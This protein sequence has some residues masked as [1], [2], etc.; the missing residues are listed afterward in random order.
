MRTTKY[1]IAFSFLLGFGLQ[2]Q[3]QNQTGESQMDKMWGDTTSG[4]DEALTHR[5]K[6][7][8]QSNFGMFVHFGIYSQ[9]AGVW[10]DTT[11]YGIGEWLMNPRV[12]NIAPKEYMVKAKDFNPELFDAHAIA[13]L[14]K[15][16]GM[17]YII[18]GAKH[19]D[20]FALFDS[21][22][23]TFDVMDASP[24]KRDVF[25]EL[26]TA[27]REAGLG[28]GFY[29][30]HYQDW[31]RPG[32][33]GGPKTNAD[34]SPA[35][36]EDYFYKKCLPQVR[37]LCSNYGPMDFV[38]FDTPGNM[39][40][41][42]VVELAAE[43]RKL[44]PNAMLCSRIGYGMGD[45]VSK[46][47]MEVPL[48]NKAGLWETCDT[49]NDSWGY[50]WYDKN[51]KTPREILERLVAT[52][53]RGGTY[54]FNI[55]PMGT[56][57]VPATAVEFLKDAGAWLARYPEVVYEAG[58]SPWGHAMP[59]GDMTTA[60]NNL[61]LTVF[62]W[63]RDGKLYLP[64]LDGRIVSAKGLSPDK[65]T[66]ISW[67]KQNGWAVLDVPF[68]PFDLP[69]S[70][71]QLKLEKPL[72]HIADTN[73]IGIHPNME[74][75]LPVDFATVTG[76]DQSE[77]KWMEKFGEWKHIVRVNNWEKEGKAEWKITVFEPGYYRVNL[78]YAGTGRLV[79]RVETDG[80]TYIQNQQGATEKC[81]AYPIGL[82][83]FDQAGIHK[84]AVS[85]IDGDPKSSSLKSLQLI[86]VN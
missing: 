73:C 78:V 50:V 47:D 14:A 48:K 68:R 35:T 49:N 63:P 26:A 67:Q 83:K 10:N 27:A 30:S 54:L 61:Y 22:T 84:I 62:D 23:D 13:K 76:A 17:K 77:S 41:E 43:V 55:G 44:Q 46:G 33:H 2:V 53:A 40:K 69:A 6:L 5:S 32:G 64:D 72:K 12:A 56:G 51:F 71:I 3:S 8:D 79:W 1:L 24:L 81:E 80:S 20:G 19:H 7:F 82:I 11:Y 66:K 36:F 58:S 42:L 28:F 9:L 18:L 25:K 21:K 59:W 86:P 85:L 39:K 37:E 57:E 4:S 45:Y 15:E 75:D 65:T 70:V 74:N 52:V 60:G 38:W 16:A 34:G 31:T 29:Y